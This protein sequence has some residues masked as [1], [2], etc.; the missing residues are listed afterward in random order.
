MDPDRLI[1]RRLTRADFPL[2]R[3]LVEQ[4]GWNQLDDDWERAIRLEPDGCFV[5]DLNGVGVATTT[6][7]RFG[8]TGWIAMVLVD[9]AARGRGVARE[10][11]A[12]AIAYLRDSG[13]Q[14]IRLDATPLGLPVYQKLGFRIEFEL[15][16]YAGRF[17][18]AAAPE[19]AVRRYADASV[20]AEIAA[21]D[22]ISAGAD[23]CSFLALLHPAAPPSFYL[24]RDQSGR[25]AGFAG[26]R[27]GRNAVQIGPV[28]AVTE[29]AGAALMADLASAFPGT[30]CFLDIPLANPGAIKWVEARGFERQRGFMRMCLGPEPRDKPEWMWA[31]S[32]PEKG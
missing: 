20:M 24:N 27:K 2:C 1:I 28:T 7:C 32:G 5:G 14:T 30:A 17:P 23:R 19:R 12:H 22:A 25:L 15:V 11:M 8:T 31:S 29:A 6:C 13:A 4:A 16:R 10:L 18:G 26:F 21:L 3:Q 9:R